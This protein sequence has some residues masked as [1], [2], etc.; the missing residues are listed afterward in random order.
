MARKAKQKSLRIVAR[1]R[2]GANDGGETRIFCERA[3]QPEQE[4][5][6]EGGWATNNAVVLHRY[7]LVAAFRFD[8]GVLVAD[9]AHVGWT[10]KE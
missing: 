4:Y 3:I 1:F 8:D 6:F 9:Y 2:G 10:Y 5:L 7:E